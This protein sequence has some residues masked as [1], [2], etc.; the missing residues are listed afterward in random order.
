MQLLQSRE[1]EWLYVIFSSTQCRVGKMIRLV[2]RNPYNHVSVCV[3]PQFQTLFSFARY[4]KNAPLYAG[5]VEESPLRYRDGK[6]PAAVKI[7]RIPVTEA[8]AGRLAQ[9]LN[10]LRLNSEEYVYNLLSAMAFPFNRKCRVQDCFTCVEFATELIGRCGIC[11]EV[12][13]DG[14]Y[15]ICELERI[16]SDR[17]IFEGSSAEI[18]PN[19]GWGR[20]SFPERTGPIEGTRGTFGSLST[21]IRRWVSG[22]EA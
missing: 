1:I 21:L 5:F 6:Q 4:H 8:Q 19:R 18:F 10:D 7:C 2:T 17:V 22:S 20:D 11:G 12:E 15:T 14:F 13:A 9:M 16:L 3:D